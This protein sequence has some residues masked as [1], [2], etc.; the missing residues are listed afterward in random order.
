MERRTSSDSVEPRAAS[1][2]APR[3]SAA[4]RSSASAR[5]SSPSTKVVPAKE[6]WSWWKVTWRRSA[7]SLASAAAFWGMNLATATATSRSRAVNPIRWA[8]PATWSSTNPA[9]SQDRDM[10]V[11]ATRR[12]RHAGRS[13]AWTRAQRRGRRYFSSS[14]EAIS[15]RPESVEV[16]SAAASSGMQNSATSGAPSP[17]SGIPVSV[18]PPARQVASRPI[19]SG[20]CCSAQVTAATSKLACARSASR[21]HARAKPSTSAGLSKPI[22]ARVSVIDIP[23]IE[24]SSTDS[25][26]RRIRICGR[27]FSP[28][29]TSAER[30]TETSTRRPT[31][32]EATSR[33]DEPDGSRASM[34]CATCPTFASPTTTTACAAMT[35]GSGITWFS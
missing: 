19:D 27:Q 32:A 21:R 30:S 35:A 25:H 8:N 9:A 12:A 24:A 20:G 18:P 13:P 17:A 29:P 23:E 6:T 33:C 26:Q 7:A 28:I 31:T 22:G 5:S 2:W 14:A 16:P 11:S 3:D 34:P 15:A 10:V 4:S 1:S